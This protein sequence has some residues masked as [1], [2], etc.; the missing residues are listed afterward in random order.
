MKMKD[1]TRQRYRCHSINILCFF[2]Q[3]SDILSSIE[4]NKT[5]RDRDDGRA[6]VDSLS[7]ISVHDPI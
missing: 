2:L 1:E 7:S 3:R 4:Q 5:V 6:P